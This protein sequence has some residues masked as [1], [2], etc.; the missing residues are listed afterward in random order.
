[1]PDTTQSGLSDNAAGGLAYV[2]IIPAIIFLVIEPFNRNPF[3]KFHCWQS[4]FLCIGCIGVDIVLVILGRIP[5]IGF[6]TL[7]LWPLVGLLFLIIWVICL[8]NAFNGKQFKLPILGD[9][10]EKQANS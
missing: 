7:F 4:I 6:F 9:L 2:T 10:A 3:V 1:M 5:F 8:V